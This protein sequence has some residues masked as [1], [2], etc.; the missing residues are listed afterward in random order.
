MGSV[1][2]HGKSC[3]V[4]HLTHL[5]SESHNRGTGRGIRAEEVREVTIDP[6]TK[7]VMHY[8]ICRILMI[9]VSPSFAPYPQ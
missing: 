3:G 9:P 1:C 5:S 7:E 6:S 4:R 2:K 8:R